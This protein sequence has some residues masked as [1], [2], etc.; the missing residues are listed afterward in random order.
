MLDSERLLLHRGLRLPPNSF[1][2]PTLHSL[3]GWVPG[4]RHRPLAPWCQAH[5]WRTGG[6]TVQE[7]RPW[8]E[9]LRASA[10]TCREVVAILRGE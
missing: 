5:L 7:W 6:F 3:C 10:E 1:D 9:Q 8:V 2:G 4:G